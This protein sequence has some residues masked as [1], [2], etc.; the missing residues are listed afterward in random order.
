MARRSTG[1]RSNATPAS[2]RARTSRPSTS[3]LMRSVSLA[4]SAIAS[5][6]SPAAASGRPRRNSAFVRIVDSGVRSSCEASA[7]NRCCAASAAARSACE[8][9]NRSIIALKLVVK[10]PTSSRLRLGARR[11]DRSPVVPIASVVSASVTR[12]RTARPATSH[13]TMATTISVTIAAITRKTR[14][15]ASWLFG[16]AADCPATTTPPSDAFAHRR[17]ATRNSGGSAPIFGARPAAAT[18][19]ADRPRSFASTTTAAGMRGGAPFSS[20]DA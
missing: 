5:A 1:R 9:C 4:T 7:T 14:K 6:R 17:A 18:V 15:P 13:D 2:A 16:K 3:R 8:D 12:G 19:A 10:R 20:P 11:F